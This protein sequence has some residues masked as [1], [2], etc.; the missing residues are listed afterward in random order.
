MCGVVT[1]I[2]DNVYVK[3]TINNYW[4]RPG[5]PASSGNQS[6]SFDVLVVGGAFVSPPVNAYGGGYFGAS[7]TYNGIG[8]SFGVPVN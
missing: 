1:G 8:N 7:A 5:P 2:P 3:V 6:H 4:Y